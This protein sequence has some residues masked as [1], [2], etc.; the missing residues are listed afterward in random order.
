MIKEKSKM[1]EDNKEL[2]YLVVPEE[3]TL[4]NYRRISSIA[5]GKNQKIFSSTE[6]AE[7]SPVLY[8]KNIMGNILSSTSYLFNKDK[9]LYL[10]DNT[11]PIRDYSFEKHGFNEIQ[12]DE[13]DLVR[14]LKE[15]DSSVK[16]LKK[17]RLKKTDRRYSLF[18]FEKNNLAKFLLG[19]E[20]INNLI[21]LSRHYDSK[22]IE[23][24]V[25]SWDP[26]IDNGLIYFHLGYQNRGLSFG[27]IFGRSLENIF[28]KSTPNLNF[29]KGIALCK[30]NIY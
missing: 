8:E 13:N 24:D 15:G 19:E 11:K 1:N 12:I 27:N 14:R 30:D 26:R 7:A 4:G 2:K 22:Y 10:Q 21:E 28:V 6:L 25:P 18:E 29:V 20:G 23:F 3:N 5:R 17:E 9:G 16:F